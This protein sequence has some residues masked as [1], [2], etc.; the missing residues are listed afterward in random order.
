[1]N[2]VILPFW[3]LCPWKKGDKRSKRQEWDEMTKRERLRLKCPT[4]FEGFLEKVHAAFFTQ[5]EN[6]R[7]VLVMGHY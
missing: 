1:M 6:S 5:S 4:G 2:V 3:G 7:H